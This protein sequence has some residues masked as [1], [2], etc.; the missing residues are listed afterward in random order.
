MTYLEGDPIGN[1]PD[2]FS[3]GATIET[4]C[5]N[6]GEWVIVY[7]KCSGREKCR[8]ELLLGNQRFIG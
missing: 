7:E 6:E 1:S 4:T 3:F 5:G 8:G 2:D